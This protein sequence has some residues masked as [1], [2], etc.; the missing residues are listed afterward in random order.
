MSL[1]SIFYKTIKATGHGISSAF[2]RAAGYKALKSHG[3]NSEA[4]SF[5]G[6]EGLTGGAAMIGALVGLAA[7]TAPPVAVAGAI[8]A[9]IVGGIL[10]HRVRASYLIGK[11]QTEKKKP[12]KAKLG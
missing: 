2:N 11:Q 3:L 7:I 8:A 9:L 6:L 4:A 10:P 1:S 5:S 12:A